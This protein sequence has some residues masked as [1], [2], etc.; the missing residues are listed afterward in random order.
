MS[1]DKA[2]AIGPRKNWETQE[3]RL[4]N[5]SSLWPSVSLA[6]RA[7]WKKTVPYAGRWITVR[8]SQGAN[9]PDSTNFRNYWSHY[10]TMSHREKKLCKRPPIKRRFFP[11]SCYVTN[12]TAP[13][14]HPF[15]SHPLE[16]LAPEADL[17]R[18][19]RA[20]YPTNIFLLLPSTPIMAFFS[21][22]SLFVHCGPLRPPFRACIYQP[23]YTRC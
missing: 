14:R 19:G 15:F 23:N 18:L 8:G 5:G 2:S 17:A 13:S 22:D 9:P 7:K 1:F 11:A 20:L 6:H 12:R 10:T 21:L 16:K 4:I 3:H